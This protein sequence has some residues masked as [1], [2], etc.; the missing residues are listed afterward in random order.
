MMIFTKKP[1]KPLLR[2]ARPQHPI[3][4]RKLRIGYAKSS[5]LMD[6]LEERGVIGPS[7]G[8]KPR[9]VIGYVQG[10]VPEEIE[11]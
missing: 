7:N 11:K 10:A 2:L 6:M 3:L 8:A 1:E 5:T 4:Q 9:E